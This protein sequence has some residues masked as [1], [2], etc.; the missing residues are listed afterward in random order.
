[1]APRIANRVPGSTAGTGSPVLPAAAMRLAALRGLRTTDELPTLE[2]WFRADVG[3]AA[4]RWT[5]IVGGVELAPA[6]GTVPTLS[7]DGGP[8]GKPCLVTTSSTSNPGI[9]VAPEDTLEFRRDVDRS[10]VAVIDPG[11][12]GASN[13]AIVCGH[14][15]SNIPQFSVTTAFRL[16]GDLQLD[17]GTGAQTD[18]SIIAAGRF[19]VVSSVWTAATNTMRF[20]VGNGAGLGTTVFAD[21]SANEITR[22]RMALFGGLEQPPLLSPPTVRTRLPGAN[23][24]MAALFTL[25]TDILAD[26]NAWNTLWA[27]LQETYPAATAPAS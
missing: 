6:G 18:V 25:N 24:K 5:D 15:Y 9:L 13:K 14:D 7:A 3:Y 4:G 20:R 19:W 12:A 22:P 1:M 23:M 11:A 26:V 17:T 27:Y 21:D 10:I 2:S 16:N 8:D